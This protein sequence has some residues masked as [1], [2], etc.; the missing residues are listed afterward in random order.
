M[1]RKKVCLLGIFF[2]VV[3]FIVSI[4]GCVVVPHPAMRAPAPEQD[5][6]DDEGPPPW[7]PA[8]GYRAKHHYRYYP[9][10]HVY[11]DDQQ[12]VYFYLSNGRWITAVSLPPTIRITINEFVTLDMDDDQPYR[13]HRDVEKR[14][15]PGQAKK[16]NQGNGRDNDRQSEKKTSREKDDDNYQKKDRNKSQDRYQSND[17]DQGRDNNKNRTQELNNKVRIK[18]QDKDRYNVQDD[19]QDQAQDNI[20]NKSQELNSKSGIK[21]ADKSQGLNK[22]KSRGKTGN[23]DKIK[24][25]G[26]NQDD[27]KD[28]NEDDDSVDSSSGAR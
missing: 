15:P 18:D 25:K 24:S 21:D 10:H 19:K 13:Y 14:Y 8:H 22:N 2:L 12:G 17:N 11:F 27:D 20:K 4:A 5:Y 3:S 28:E 6:S 23:A 9:Y 16:F 26:K 7:A 1:N